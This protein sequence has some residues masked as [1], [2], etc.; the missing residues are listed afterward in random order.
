MSKSWKD[1]LLRSG[2]PLEADVKRYLEKRGCI[3]N[4][5]FSYLKPDE[6]EVE[7]QFSCDIDAA[8]V[9]PAHF[10]SLLVECKYRHQGVQWVFVP[11]DYGGPD[12]FDP[13]LFMHPFDHFVSAEFPF[14]GLFPRR[15][16]PCCSKGIEI[17]NDGANEKSIDQALAQ[18]AFAFAPKVADACEHQVM[19]LLGGEIIFYHVPVIVTTAELFRLKDEVSIE[20]IRAAKSLEGVA[21]KHDCLVHSYTAGIELRRYSEKAMEELRRKLGD[22]TLTKSLS[23]FTNDLDHFFDV[24][25]GH[26][27]PAAVIVISVAG[28]WGAFDQL[29]TYMDE[30][31]DPSPALRAEL[32]AQTEKFAKL[33]RDLAARLAQRKGT[34]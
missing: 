31:I 4:F 5:E 29:F 11:R 15:L 14:S 9:R 16:A 2:V 30:L 12:E 22:Q 32:A 13:N 27:C 3:V 28:G 1:A 6:H 20:T 26:Y 21:T 10:I 34:E 17:T 7:R 8:Y 24:I 19:R 25:V 33:Q 18:L 23:T